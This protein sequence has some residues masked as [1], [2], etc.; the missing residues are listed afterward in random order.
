MPIDITG[1]NAGKPQ[2]TSERKSPAV[3]RNQGGSS[4]GASAQ[5]PRGDTINLTATAARLKQLEAGLVGIPVLSREVPA[6]T[7][8]AEKE[9][10]IFSED[11]DAS[12]VA[13]ELVN[14]LE[15][16][17]VARLRQR[18]RK[19]YTWQAIFE[20]RIQ[21]LLQAEKESQKSA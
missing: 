11:S 2:G 15:R 19:Q 17:P 1:L 9:S 16:S 4:A 12:F 7:E 6:A 18:V 3:E 20:D 21:P 8:L 10:L 13:A 5:G 14:M